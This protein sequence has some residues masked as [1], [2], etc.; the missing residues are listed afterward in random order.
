M[1]TTPLGDFDSEQ[2]TLT[3]TGIKFGAEIVPAHFGPDERM[4][5]APRTWASTLE[6][7][8]GAVIR[9]RFHPAASTFQITIMGMDDAN[10]QLSDGA[11]QGE[12]YDFDA[13][14]NNGEGS[15][16]TG[17]CWVQEEPPWQKAKEATPSVWTMGCKIDDQ[18][19]GT[20]KMV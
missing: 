9:N 4:N 15:F 11:K 5:I 20:L 12:I 2:V 18:N 8:G 3:L 13:V 7:Q 16:S 6:G 10:K 14:D 19:Q 17:K 1:G